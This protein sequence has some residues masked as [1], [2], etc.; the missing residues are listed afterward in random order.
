VINVP[1]QKY[2][3]WFF[4]QVAHA[5]ERLL[6]ADYDGALAPFSTDR[7]L[8][9]PFPGVCDLL[10]CVMQWRTR[11]I[12]ISARPAHEVEFLLGMQPAP[13]IWGND[14]LEHLHPGGRY[15]C[16]EL[17]APLEVLR[18]LAEC[19]LRLEREGLKY[20]VDV[21]LTGVT[22]HWRGLTPFEKLATRTAAYR[23]LQ[24][25]TFIYKQLRLV[26]IEEGVELRLPV[27]SKADAVQC[28][29]DATPPDVPVAYLG[30]SVAN[31]DIFRALNDRGLT[32]LV[33]PVP[34]FTAAQMRLRPPDELVRF[35]KD[36][37][38]ACAGDI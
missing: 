17:N 30:H 34:R 23:V 7:G 31:E 38:S 19:E 2:H 25:L 3:D 18:A 37:I 27:A 1:E 14:G 10:K 33:K 11:L 36:W 22:V 29:L 15:E 21:K 12:A 13:E 32:V 9:S 4:N 35:L 5:R 20:R 8:A 24:P 26:T 6:L 16:G 28:L